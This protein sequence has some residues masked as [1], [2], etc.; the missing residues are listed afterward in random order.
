MKKREQ[1]TPLLRNLES[2][3]I[4]LRRI[5]CFYW[6]NTSAGTAINAKISINYESIIAFANC[7]NCAFSFASTATNAIRIDNVCHK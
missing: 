5:W 7:R 2:Y 3:R 1:N 6:A 4:E